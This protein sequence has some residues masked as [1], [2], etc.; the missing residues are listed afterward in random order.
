MQTFLPYPDFAQSAAVLDRGRLGKQRVE[1]KQIYLSLRGKGAWVNHPAVKMWAG[2]EQAL[3]EY[4]LA[5]C[6]EWRS[7]GYAD[8]LKPWFSR[9]INWGNYRP[10][11]AW[12]GNYAFH[13]S[14]Q[15]NLVRKDAKH[16]RGYFPDVPADLPYVWPT[17]A[18]GTIQ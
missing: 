10:K 17:R 2:Y 11:P 14:H 15:S 8:T 5:V 13:L 3:L 6:S 12:L 18:Q 4:G 9:R 7:R 1:A 16:Y